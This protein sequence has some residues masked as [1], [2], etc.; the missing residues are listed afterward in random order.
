MISLLKIILIGIAAVII[1]TLVKAY[2]PEFTVE[3][4]LCASIIL[5]YFIIDGFSYGLAYITQVYD[6]LSYGKEYFPI[7]VKVLA[8][9]YITEFAVALCQDAGEK[10]IASKLEL[11]GKVAIFISAIPIFNSLLSLLNNLT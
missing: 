3:I 8:I 6:K 2:K 5:L 1:I 9:A 4:T 7:I 11:A 10:A